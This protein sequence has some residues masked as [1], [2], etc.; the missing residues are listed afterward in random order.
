MHIESR[1]RFLIY[2]SVIARVPTTC[3]TDSAELSNYFQTSC[4]AA[5]TKSPGIAKLTIDEHSNCFGESLTGLPI[6][7]VDQRDIFF[8]R[9]DLVS[10]VVSQEAVALYWYPRYRRNLVCIR[11]RN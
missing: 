5:R 1:N 4:K 6:S 3:F 11:P 8:A 9:T 10:S 2:I 7:P